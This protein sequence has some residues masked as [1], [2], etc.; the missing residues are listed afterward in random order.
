MMPPDTEVIMRAFLRRCLPLPWLLRARRLCY[1]PLELG[2]RLLG[3]Y[4][5]SLPPRWLRFVGG[6]DFATIGDCL[7]AHCGRLVR[8]RRCR[9][10]FHAP[11]A[12]G[13][14]PLPARDSPR[15]T[16]RW[17]LSGDVLRA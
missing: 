16:A 7:L 2:Q 10:G 1:L 14:G 6:G 12:D 17:A 9:V 13:G 11:A 3:G 4:D 15:V 5:P 8:P